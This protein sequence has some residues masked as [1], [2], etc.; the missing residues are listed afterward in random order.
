MIENDGGSTLQWTATSQ[1]PSFLTMDTLNGQTTTQGTI[2]F[3][4]NVGSLSPG[5]YVG[6]I[7]VNAGTAGTASVTVNV[8]L[9][10]ILYKIHLP[11]VV[12]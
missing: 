3:T 7:N 11:L 6:T 4:L 8:K 2:A 10:A 9:V 5:D 1:P 12:R